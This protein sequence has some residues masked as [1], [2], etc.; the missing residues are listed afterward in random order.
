MSLV[1]IGLLLTFFGVLQPTQAQQPSTKVYGEGFPH[2]AE[3]EGFPAVSPI[4]IASPTNTIY[5]TNQVKLDFT[6][7]SFF[8]NSNGNITMTY[9]LDGK[10][11]V[12]IP[13]SIVFT[14]LYYTDSDGNTRQA[15]QGSHYLISCS[16]DLDNLQSGQH[17][18]TV[19]G[20]Y[21]LYSMLGKV[22]LDS[23]TVEFTI[24]DGSS[25]TVFNL[26]AEGVSEAESEPKSKCVHASVGLFSL[27]AVVAICALF[28]KRKQTT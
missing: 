23:K 26:D 1:F 7:K 22:G 13:M 10:D 6:V 12:T 16:V 2:T 5:T 14:P 21:E 20:R 19:F 11:P 9:S 4:S 3:G 17:S 25:Q 8:D 15:I 27:V 24:D 28:I 18:L